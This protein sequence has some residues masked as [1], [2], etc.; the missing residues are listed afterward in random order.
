MSKISIE[1]GRRIH[2][3]RTGC[4]MTLEELASA[5]YKSKATISKYERGDITMDIDTLYDIATAL[6][7]NVDQLLINNIETRDMKIHEIEPAFFKG[8]HRLYAYYYDGRN[9]K[10]NRSVCDIMSKIDTNKYKLVM[11]MN[12][13]DVENY[14]DCENIYTGYIQHFDA[15][16]IIEVMHQTNPM[17]LGSIQ[18]LA[19][20][21]ETTYKWGLWNGVSSRPLM[22]VALKM[23]FSK[24]IMKEDTKLIDL[25]KISKE[26]IRNMK[27]FNFFSV[28]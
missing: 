4:G 20:F 16:S 23:L 17:E 7:I 9:Q 21:M 2:N 19:S 1:T 14:Q 8:V 22:P 18:I 6:H 3:F 24:K 5:V 25:L 26:D 27:I 11:Y 15:M 12:C 13:S 10:I 28:T